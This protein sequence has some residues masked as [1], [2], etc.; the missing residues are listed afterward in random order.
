MSHFFQREFVEITKSIFPE[1]FANQR[2]LEIGSL[3][4]C[5]TVRGYFE[6]CEY[7]GL[8]I[9]PGPGVDLVCE[10]QKYDAP[11]GSFDVVISC[12]VMEHNPYWQATLQNMVRLLRPGGLMVMS[13]ATAWRREHGTS[14]SEPTS[15]PLTIARGWEHYGNVSRRDILRQV[16]LTPLSTWSIVTNWE[17]LDLYFLGIKAPGNAEA[18][19]RIA[20]FESIY[21]KRILPDWK[22]RAGRILQSPSRIVTF[23]GMLTSAVRDRWAG[24]EMD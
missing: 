7:T 15:S 10:G 5:G 1:M 18:A 13:C 24:E 4:L 16:D 6:H 2:V 20:Q 17:A 22:R 11:D 9:G 8:D 3:D 14:R 23:L 19:Q 12:E 21:R